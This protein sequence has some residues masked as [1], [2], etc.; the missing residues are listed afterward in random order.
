MKDS[1][2]NERQRGP[3]RPNA[4][5][6][7]G[8]GRPGEAVALSTLARGAWDRDLDQRLG[9]AKGEARQPL[10]REEVT[11]IVTAIIGSMAGDLSAADIKLYSELEALARYIH[12]ARTE[13][14]AIR[15][16]DI[17]NEHIPRATDEL[18]AVVGATEDAT[19]RIMDSCEA[20]TAIAARLDADSAAALARAV[21]SVFE[22]CNFQDIT[23]QR[24]AKV[25]KTLKHI[26][27]KIIAPLAAFGDGAERPTVIG[28][29]GAVTGEAACA[30][31]DGMLHGPALPRDAVDQAT[32][33]RLLAGAD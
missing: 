23:G 4:M 7:R 3:E 26:E 16:D 10:S 14:A 13:I 5:G 17:H 21:T 32:I 8:T 28:T 27:A 29:A 33:D 18:D 2:V 1:A 11:D 25:V 15:P 6:S 9:V 20:S 22:A 24:I 30:G 31:D 12:N 19:H